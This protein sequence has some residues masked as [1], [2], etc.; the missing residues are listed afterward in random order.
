M[1]L[2]VVAGALG[3]LE[4]PLAVRLWQRPGHGVGSAAGVLYGLDLFG[5]CVGA[6]VVTPFL[7]P[8]VG[9]VGICWWTALLNACTLA[10]LLL[11]SRYWS[12]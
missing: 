9:L 11:P 6:A 3:G 7:L 5:A 12:S 4:F 1:F 10:F 2:P 8:V